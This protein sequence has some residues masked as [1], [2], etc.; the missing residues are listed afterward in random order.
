MNT[1]KDG[2]RIVGWRLGTGKVSLRNGHNSFAGKPGV[3][4]TKN[5]TRIKQGILAGP[6]PKFDSIRALLVDDSPIILK[7]LSQILSAEDRFTVVGSAT[8]GYQA[9]RQTLALD[10]DLVL[11][12][13]HLSHMNGPQ[14][15]S[16]IK[17][18]R[19]PPVV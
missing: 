13:F 6:L 19:N 16:Y 14:V 11:M 12:G 9:L 18:F 17:Q 8:D 4:P 7:I 15:T 10:P 2:N 3:Q 5:H 1:S